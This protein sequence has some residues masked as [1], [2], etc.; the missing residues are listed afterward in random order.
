MSL[1][2][3]HLFFLRLVWDILQTD[4][5]CCGVDFPENWS[6][7]PWAA[8]QDTPVGLNVQKDHFSTNII[9]FIIPL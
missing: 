4:F 2:I 5:S 8:Q 9:Y 7:T 6:Q 3:Y 1:I